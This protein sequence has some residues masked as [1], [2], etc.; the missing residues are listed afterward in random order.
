[1]KFVQLRSL[2]TTYEND[3]SKGNG[4]GLTDEKVALVVRLPKEL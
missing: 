2:S 1:M 4:L 3:K